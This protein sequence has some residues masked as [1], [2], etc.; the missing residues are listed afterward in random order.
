MNF[1]F[2][3]DMFCYSD[4]GIKPGQRYNTA[5]IRTTLEKLYKTKVQLDCNA[6][7]LQKVAL[8]FNIIGRDGY[9]LTDAPDQGTCKDIIKYSKK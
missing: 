8:Y 2:I 5:D 3:K 4:G 9:I 1:C 7:L 6:D